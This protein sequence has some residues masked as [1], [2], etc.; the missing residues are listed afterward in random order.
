[1]ATWCGR[2]GAVTVS[3]S[4]RCAQT[5]AADV[6]VPVRLWHGTDDRNV[7]PSA[8]KFLAARLPD[9]EATTLPGEDHLSALLACHERALSWLVP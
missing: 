6:D 7:S 3:S 5:P 1:M 4:R 8:A 9:A 2:C